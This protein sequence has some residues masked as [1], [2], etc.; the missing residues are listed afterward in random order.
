VTIQE[1]VLNHLHKRFR[2]LMLEPVPLNTDIP[3]AYQAKLPVHR[4]NASAPATKAYAA[5]AK[6]VMNRAQKE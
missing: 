5:V 4:Y 2:G 6:E 1:E 3:E